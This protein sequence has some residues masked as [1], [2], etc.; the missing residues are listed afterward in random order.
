VVEE[1]QHWSPLENFDYYHGQSFS[2]LVGA[3]QDQKDYVK[4]H[5]DLDCPSMTATDGSVI[6]GMGTYGYLLFNPHASD[7]TPASTLYG[8]GKEDYPGMDSHEEIRVQSY[9]VSSTRMEA[10]AILGHH[11]AC[12]RIDP[13]HA[14]D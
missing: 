3:E 13:G 6:E 9:C 2:N 11:S 1:E 5:V 12:E 8:G 7:E 10:Y 4:T 14:L